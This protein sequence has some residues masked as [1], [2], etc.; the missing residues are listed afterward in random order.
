MQMCE[1][2]KFADISSKPRTIR[3]ANMVIH[4]TGGNNMVCTRA[5]ESM[6]FDMS[7]GALWCSGYE[8]RKNDA[9]T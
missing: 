7:T 2:C 5:I 8:R 4:Q 1:T 3:T 9:G 6:T